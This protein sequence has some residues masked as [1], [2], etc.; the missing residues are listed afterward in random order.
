MVPG[1]TSM[2]IGQVQHISVEE[3]YARG[4]EHRYN[5]GRFHDVSTCPLRILYPEHQINLQ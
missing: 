2:V 1:I 5:K 4:Y 3:K